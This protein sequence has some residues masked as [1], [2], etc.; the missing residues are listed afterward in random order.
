[1]LRESLSLRILSRQLVI[2]H[3]FLGSPI[4][5]YM[6]VQLQSTFVVKNSVSIPH[7]MLLGAVV[8]S[9]AL[10]PVN[11][12]KAN[13]CADVLLDPQPSVVLTRPFLGDRAIDSVMTLLF[14]SEKGRSLKSD[15]FQPNDFM[16]MAWNSKGLSDFLKL[17]KIIKPA[18]PSISDKYKILAAFI[19]RFM[20]DYRDKEHLELRQDKVLRRALELH[21]ISALPGE[22]ARRSLRRVS[23]TNLKRIL[24]FVPELPQGANTSEIEV[25]VQ[26]LTLT[27]AHNSHVMAEPVGLPVL[28][29]S[30]FEKIGLSNFGMSSWAFNR[31]LESDHQVYFWPMFRRSDSR[32]GLESEYGRYGVVT[33][34]KYMRSQGWVSAFVMY[35]NQLAASVRDID[36]EAAKKIDMLITDP[37]QMREQVPVELQSPIRSAQNRLGTFD[38]TP[39]DYEYIV[40][41]ILVHAL[42]E[43]RVTNPKEYTVAM[44]AF[45]SGDLNEINLYVKVLAL[46]KFG[47]NNASGFE[48][49]IPVAVPDSELIHFGP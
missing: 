10:T 31:F 4:T 2:N 17:K 40:R 22:L 42:F 27:F 28:A 34:Q 41:R 35:A 37:M 9:T 19:K 6:V 18:Q 13:A 26:Q 30:E 16:E 45:S 23:K 11:L 15:P 44:K 12:A 8:L 29:P 43:L 7:F 49:K 47:L 14:Y 46:T 38:F 20:L 5:V 24:G 33:K 3:W 32:V 36:S 48:G 1:M 25:V 21:G 39:D